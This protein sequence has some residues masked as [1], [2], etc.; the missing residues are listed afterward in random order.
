MFYNNKRESAGTT[1]PEYE[2]EIPLKDAG[3]LLNNFCVAALEKIRYK[4]IYKNKLWELDEF[5][6][7]NEGLIVA[8]IELKKMK[9]LK[10][11]NGLPM[12]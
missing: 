4:I 1:R 6:E 7:E 5:L 8:E 2:Y 3:E 12:K 10:F 11:L 9:F